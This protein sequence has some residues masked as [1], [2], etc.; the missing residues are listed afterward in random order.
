MFSM[1][2]SHGVF[3]VVFILLGINNLQVCTASLF[4]T[5]FYAEGSPIEILNG[6]FRFCKTRT[7]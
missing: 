2:E 7:Q 5:R 3:V 4:K 6:P 1:Q